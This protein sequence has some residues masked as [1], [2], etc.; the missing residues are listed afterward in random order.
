MTLV[1]RLVLALAPLLLIGCEDPT[2]VAGG[3][4]D[5]LSEE[6][7]GVDAN[8]QASGDASDD[9]RAGDE[10]SD[11]RLDL[12]RHLPKECRSCLQVRSLE[13]CRFEIP[14]TKEDIERFGCY[15]CGCCKDSAT[16]RDDGPNVSCFAW[17]RDRE[18][19]GVC[20]PPFPGGGGPP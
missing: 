9:G 20:R 18:S 7:A 13:D 10:R 12:W 15:E 8:A 16:C 5:S 6:D 14:P 17:S 1:A 4:S 11:P 3:D 19:V 2:L